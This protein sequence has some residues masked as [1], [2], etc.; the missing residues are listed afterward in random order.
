M[1]VVQMKFMKDRLI[2]EEETKKKY[3]IRKR[4]ELAATL[5]ERK[6]RIELKWYDRFR[7]FSEERITR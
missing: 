3:K 1:T 2:K 4:R 5:L 6:P 7:I